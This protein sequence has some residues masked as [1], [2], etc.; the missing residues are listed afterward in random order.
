M[1]NLAFFN[2]FRECAKIVQ[3][4]MRTS[5][6]QPREMASFIRAIRE[7]I[8]I[9]IFSLPNRKISLFVFSLCAKRV[10]PCPNPV[11]INTTW[12]NLRSFL[13][14][15]GRLEWA[16][17]AHA[18]VSLR[19]TCANI[20]IYF[21]ILSGEAVPGQ[22]ENIFVL[23][24]KLDKFQIWTCLLFHWYTTPAIF[25][26]LHVWPQWPARSCLQQRSLPGHQVKGTGP[27]ECRIQRRQSWSYFY[28][29]IMF[30]L[31]LW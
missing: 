20:V 1:T 14:I 23:H 21:M 24:T 15:I 16:L 25:V 19:I 2:V 8:E 5:I 30:N 28:Y 22:F 7:Q 11:N 26:L 6:F 4:L 29:F 17:P 27:W 3:L 9:K 18:I 31:F 10:K 13:S 12:K